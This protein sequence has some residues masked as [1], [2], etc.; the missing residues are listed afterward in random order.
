MCT[1]PAPVFPSNP[2]LSAAS[3][4]I[5]RERRFRVSFGQER[6]VGVTLPV[7]VHQSREVLFDKMAETLLLS[8]AL[9]KQRVSHRCTSPQPYPLLL[10]RPPDRSAGR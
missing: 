2:M 4:V 1:S 3:W 8:M 7:Q 6:V 5:R 10:P 9:R